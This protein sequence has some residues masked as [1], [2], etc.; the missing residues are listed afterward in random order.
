MNELLQWGG[1]AYR[2]RS[3]IYV[4]FYGPFVDVDQYRNQKANEKLS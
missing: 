4:L 3:M 1:L 2:V